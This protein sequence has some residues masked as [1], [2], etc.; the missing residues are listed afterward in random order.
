M[1]YAFYVD[2]CIIHT[3]A[4]TRAFEPLL[5][6]VRW[7]ENCNEARMSVSIRYGAGNMRTL[8]LAEDAKCELND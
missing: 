6:E 5:R 8:T 2:V 4:L 1:T 7:A 3:Y